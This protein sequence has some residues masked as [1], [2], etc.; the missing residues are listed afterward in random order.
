MG[1]T[2]GGLLRG[3]TGASRS[4]G[5]TGGLSSGGGTCC[6]FGTVDVSFLTGGFSGDF[7]F[8]GQG[9]VF[10]VLEQCQCKHR[11]LLDILISQDVI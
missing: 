9:P 2:I 11:S 3:V 5:I 1:G 8:I 4:G 7:G 6:L 10:Q